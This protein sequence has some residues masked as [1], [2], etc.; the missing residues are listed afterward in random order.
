MCGRYRI[1]DTDVLTAHLRLAFGIPDWVKDQNKPR[2]NIAPSQECPAIIMNDE[3]DVLPI[4]M[5]M[6]WGFIPYWERSEKPNRV[7]IN[8]VAD[9]VTSLRMFSQSAQ[10]RRC[11]IP[12]DGFYEWLR[13]D[14]KTK[15][16]FDIHL[17]GNRPFV[18]AGIYE[19]ATSLRPPTFAILTTNP[20]SVVAKIHKRM[21]AI[22]DDDEAKRWLR[23][24][25]MTAEEIA[26]LTAPHPA[27]DTEAVPISSLVNSPRNDVPEILE[28]VGFPPPAAQPKP[29]QGELF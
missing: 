19:K 11:L 17:K 15:Y 12:S 7:P 6:R 9:T 26:Q 21:P 28:P 24:G 13:L 4:P 27:D 14:E 2:Y 18:M 1:K 10:R 25:P 29:I 22:L 23:L 3:G 20:N 8:A 16:P 5:M